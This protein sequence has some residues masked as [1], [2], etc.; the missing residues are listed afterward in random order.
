MSND[1]GG[2]PAFPVASAFGWSG[3]IT[4]HIPGSVEVLCNVC[5]CECNLF[6]SITFQRR[7]KLREVGADPFMRSW[8]LRRI[9]HPPL[10]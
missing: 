7:S 9:E 5:F 3:S 4:I 10:L 6:A 2:N 8:R 1:A